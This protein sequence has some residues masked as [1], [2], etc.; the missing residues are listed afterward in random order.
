MEA[1]LM[2]CNIPPGV[3][4]QQWPFQR[5]PDYRED[6]WLKVLKRINKQFVPF[7]GNIIG[8]DISD[9]SIKL[10]RSYLDGLWQLK[11]YCPNISF[12]VADC[13]SW[14]IEKDLA[15]ISSQ[16]GGSNKGANSRKENDNENQNNNHL[17]VV[18]NPPWGLRLRSEPTEEIWKDLGFFL[19]NNIGGGE[20]W[21][22][23]GNK[24]SETTKH[25]ALKST[26]KIPL[27]IGGVQTV[28]VN[29]NILPKWKDEFKE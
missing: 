26:K 19:K 25:L 22:L 9:S 13:V 28:L 27:K 10:A 14:E 11:N 20:A 2:A 18:T 1:L 5:W 3:L 4:R 6:L 7:Y 29:Y 16:K 15:Q 12:R 8:S 21:V 23:T 17:M 24:K